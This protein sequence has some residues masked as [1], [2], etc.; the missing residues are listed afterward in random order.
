MPP[1]LLVP[2]AFETS[3]E[4]QSAGETPLDYI[5]RWVRRRMPEYGAATGAL[6]DRILIV[7]ART[8]SG[9]ST[10]LPVGL[11]RLLRSETSHGRFRGPGVICTQPRVLTAIALANDMSSSPHY[12]D[13]VL[14]ETVGYVT[15]PVKNR[16]A[17]GLTYATA[18][19]LAAQF[20]A[21]TDTEIMDRFRFILID[22]AHERSLES[23]MLLMQLRN[24]CRRN[25]GDPRLPFVV[26]MSA[27]IEPRRYAQ[28]FGVENVIDVAGSSYP[29]TTHW[30]AHGTNNYLQAAADTALAIHRDGVDDPPERSD[31]L[32]FMP[33]NAE[34]RA[35][36][37]LLLQKKREFDVLIINGDVVAEQ[38]RD[39]AR[40]F[41]PPTA[42][43]RIVLSTV[44]A[45]TGLTIDTLRYVIDCGWSRSVEAYPRWRLHGLVTRPAARSR[46]TQRAGRCGRLFPGD[47]HPLYTESTHQALP[48][49]QPPD[50]V[51]HGVADVLLAAVAASQR[52][53]QAL[54]PPLRLTAD[55]FAPPPWRIDELGLL[56]PPPA[57]ALQA[58]VAEATLAGF[59]TPAGLTPLGEV[60][61]QLRRATMAGARVL[62][63]GYCW[64]VA[65][66]DL[67]TAV[68]V[69]DHA[70]A[71]FVNAR[72]DPRAALLAAWPLSTLE[73]VLSKESVLSEEAKYYQIRLT[74]ADDYAELVLLYDAYAAAVRKAQGAPGAVAAWC[75]AHSLWP[76]AMRDIARRREE[77]AEEMIVAGLNPFRLEERRLSAQ[78]SEADLTRALVAFKRCLRD[79]LRLG[80]IRRRELSRYE[81][82]AGDAVR[83]P[84]LFSEKMIAH[85][86]AAGLVTPA[87]PRAVMTDTL[88]L[89]PKS[90][91]QSA[92]LRYE[93]K[94]GLISVL[95]G[96]IEDD[97]DFCQPRMFPSQPDTPTA[98]PTQA[99]TPDPQEALRML[100]AYASIARR[101]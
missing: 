82:V 12:P 30:P 15:G 56:D 41:A 70:A 9:K 57:A 71:D 39:Y 40:L 64:G 26:I 24:F 6:A 18:G 61:A 2:G 45:E 69:F 62:L 80:V 74:L 31:I 85:I 91:D 75:E 100:E 65:G 42:R 27:T 20:A 14:G 4:P 59:L 77:I 7:R 83:V 73:S 87:Q 37:E 72:K 97:E 3:G 29:I 58:A 33:G 78:K 67:L 86:A 88:R 94:T 51:T 84:L 32:I 89:M 79:G 5:S 34:M 66:S 50:I 95:D 44:V 92:P 13:M 46:L 81:T 55:G 63:A 76:E 54:P 48:E 1:T 98:N 47:F 68:A 52:Q 22:E 49:Q 8:G 53:H 60:A 96:F 43:R 17:G 25:D 19:I 35:V 10:V 23:D 101:S 28:Y 21:S 11:F 16:P 93:I 90:Q 99:A 38:G 36:A